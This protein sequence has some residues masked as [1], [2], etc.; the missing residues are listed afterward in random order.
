MAGHDAPRAAL[1]SFVTAI[2]AADRTRGLW[3]TVYGIEG[4]LPLVAAL[5]GPDALVALARGVAQAGSRWSD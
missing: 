4:M 3:Q 2:W 1:E 5:E